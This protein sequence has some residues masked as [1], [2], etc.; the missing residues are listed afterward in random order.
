MFQKLTSAT[1]N[2]EYV[3]LPTECAQYNCGRRCLLSGVLAR[4]LLKSHGGC[5]FVALPGC[6]DLFSTVYLCALPHKYKSQVVKSGECRGQRPRP[7]SRPSKLSRSVF[8]IVKVLPL[9]QFPFHIVVSPDDGQNCRPKH[10]VT[11]M[12]KR[13]LER[14]WCCVDRITM[15]D[16]G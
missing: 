6:Q 7:I 5:C 15:E 16:V 2:A 12:N 3:A 8:K 4:K 9:P 1:F 14:L 11:L 10:V 13:K